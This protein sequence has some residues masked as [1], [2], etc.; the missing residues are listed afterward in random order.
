M[1]KLIGFVYNTSFVDCREMAPGTV[2]LTFII[3]ELH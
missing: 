3:M 2:S 1:C